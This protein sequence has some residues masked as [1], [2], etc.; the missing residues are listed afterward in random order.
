MF[1]QRLMLKIT[2]LATNYVKSNEKNLL[3]THQLFI[4][5]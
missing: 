4:H 5:Y 2:T 1:I 3:N